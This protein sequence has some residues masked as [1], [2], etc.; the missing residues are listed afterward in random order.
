MGYLHIDNLYKNQEILLFKECFALEKIHGTSAHVAHKDGTLRFFAGGS[1]HESFVALF[2]QEALLEKLQGLN[3]T[4]Y[5]ESY[6]GKTQGMSETYGKE[7]KFIA[8]DLI[9]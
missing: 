1:K 7:M 8:T 6:G 4:I 3:V 2:D 5:G 9:F